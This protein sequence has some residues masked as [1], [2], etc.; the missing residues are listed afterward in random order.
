MNS[1]DQHFYRIDRRHFLT[2][3]SSLGLVSTLLPG[4]LAAAS[5][6]QDTITTE[7][8]KQAEKIAGLEFNEQKREEII[9]RLN[10]N[11][12]GYRKLRSLNM[13][14]RTPFSLYFNPIPP[15]RTYEPQKRFLELSDIH[16]E[17]PDQAEDTAFYP[18][19]HL[20]KLLKEKKISSID[21]T[22]MYLARLKRYDPLLKCVVTLTED[23]AL[24]QAARA[25]REIASG[26]YRG[27]LHG[28][29][30]GVK[31]LF[32]TKG[33]PTTWGLERYK[34]RVIDTDATVVK[35]L[36]AAGAVLIAKLSLGEL[37]TG[38][39][40][41]GGM[42]RN[43]WNHKRGSGGSSAGSASAVAAGLVGF[44]IGTET[45]E[46]LV[47][48]A[49]VCGVNG[50]RPTFG[51]VSRYGVMTTSWSYDKIGPM[52]RSAEDCAIVL[53]AICGPDDIDHSVIDLPF[54]WDPHINM[55]TLRVG[56]I[57]DLFDLTPENE[58]V[59]SILA[60]HKEALKRIEVMGANIIEIK[61]TNHEYLATLIQVSSLGMMVEAAAAHEGLALNMREKVFGYSDWAKR[62]RWAR[63]VP[64]IDYVQ[65]NRARSLLIEE[66]DEIF[67]RVDVLIGRVTLSAL[68]SNITG[69]PELVIPHG[70]D[71]ND[72]P[73]G[74]IL[75]G[76]LFGESA[77]I[78]LAHTYQMKTGYHQIH[79]DLK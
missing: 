43:P 25:D 78:K 11:R 61:N 28:I 44:S 57:K 71:K 65:A 18:I 53:D 9:G 63:Y 34:N 37:A 30:W 72:M 6:D 45:N 19:T 75:T 64:A 14:N 21:L 15:G 49:M 23:L 22:K 39:R 24:E 48:P 74:I 32:A 38:D 52:C 5:Q 33:I 35:R 31:D 46:S 54:N 70:L 51:R 3:F 4:A 68:Q 8:M 58:W 26:N 13:E 50:L 41:Y 16:V 66:A 47:G 27:P 79:P 62:F 59:A 73:V 40:W 77:L 29:P 76:K 42:T 17:K 1:M 60:V 69:H 55:K 36:E 2:V 7:M 20:S 56:Y 12:I 10:R 67:Q